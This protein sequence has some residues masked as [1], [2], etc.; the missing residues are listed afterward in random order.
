[1]VKKEKQ[2]KEQINVN[3]AYEGAQVTPDVAET[4]VGSG[5]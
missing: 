4:L 5:K 1:M 3:D 2:K